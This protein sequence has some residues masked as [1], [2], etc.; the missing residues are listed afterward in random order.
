MLDPKQDTYETYDDDCQNN[1]FSANSPAVMSV[2]R[3]H[4]ASLLPLQ[5]VVLFILDL[6]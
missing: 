6:R 3:V 4:A 2:D 1:I 5:H